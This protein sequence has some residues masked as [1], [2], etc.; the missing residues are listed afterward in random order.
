MT[1]PE[2]AA[3]LE[4]LKRDRAIWAIA[5]CGDEYILADSELFYG[6]QL[7][8][9]AKRF[10]EDQKVMLEEYKQQVRDLRFKLTVG[11]TKKS[12]EVKLGKTI[13]K[14]C[15]ALPGFPY[16]ALDCRA[17]FDPIDYVVFVG[18]SRG[19]VSQLDFVD[20]KTGRARLN[21]VQQ[22]IREAVEDG[23]VRLRS[24]ET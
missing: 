11:F 6:D 20:V 7:P 17:L 5:P 13:E 18:A 19:A 15:P 24:V 16:S 8:L 2:I 21:E 10:V 3:V 12:V 4:A 14:I 23:K 1:R 9:G 22:E